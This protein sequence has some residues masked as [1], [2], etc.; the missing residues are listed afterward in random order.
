MMRYVLTALF[1]LVSVMVGQKSDI[2]GVVSDSAS[3]E[4][5]PYATVRIVELSRGSVTNNNGFYLIAGIPP[6]VYT[7]SAH[8]IGYPNQS[9]QVTI[10]GGG[11]V[12]VNFGLSSAPVELMGVEVIGGRKSE[13]SEISTSTHV[14]SQTDISHVPVIGQGDLFRSI[15][16]LP[17][18]VS[19]A[20]V[21]SKFFVRGGGGDQN[22]IL[23]DGLKI[24]NPFHA[25]G[26]FSI[27]DPEIVKSTEVYTGGFPAG[28][29][30]RLSSVVNII[31][32][33]GNNT[34]FKGKAGLN[35][36]SGSLQLE[37]PLPNNNSWIVSMRR[38]LFDD[39][40]NKFLR[41]PPPISFYDLF[42]KAKFG[43]GIYGNYSANIFIS[44]DDIVSP[45]PDEPDHFWNTTAASL[46]ISDLLQDRVYYETIISVN[47]FSISR[48]AKNSLLIQPAQSSIRDISIRTDLTMY[49][50]SE[51]LYFLGFEV[52]GIRYFFEYTTASKK[53][54][55]VDKSN[56]EFWSWFRYRTRIGKIGLDIGLHSDLI[57]LVSA[58]ELTTAFQ[59]RMNISYTFDNEWRL[60]GSYGI[61]TQRLMTLTNE[62]DIVS[63]FEA[64]I[65]VPKEDQ[66]QKASHYTIGLEGNIF[67]ELSASVQY[68]LKNYSSLALY[69]RD[70]KFASDP[71]YMRGTGRAYGIETMV[72][73]SFSAVDLYLAYTWGKTEVSIG[74]YTYPP[75]YDRR[76][77]LHL[78]G[79][80]RVWDNIECSV[81]WELGSGYAYS[82]TIG[83]YQRL[84]LSGLGRDSFVD[85]TGSGYLIIGDKNA[86]R[87]PAYHR[88]DITMT[89]RFHF[90][91]LAGETGVSIINAYD[92]RNILY[93]D[94]KTSQTITMLPFFPA[95]FVRV[96]F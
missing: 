40:Y 79:I 1:C 11:P 92:N 28:F 50:E 3:G 61:F 34:T 66:P 87:M 60:K 20:D 10:R 90:S 54:I 52:S 78:L 57:G 81:K 86:A 6:G 58:S 91:L 19:T 8:S 84:T 88:M 39:S 5:I 24:Y 15:Q 36:L 82:Q 14:L 30:G 44:Q 62:D 85:E 71:D 64:W 38:S 2:R 95:A 68:Y 73:Y 41:N 72:R 16:I 83:L 27:I 23:L 33:D 29:G 25:F 13:I 59:P 21:S 89:Y 48:N 37:G 67:S 65:M 56:G 93:Y 22:L 32:E 42:A 9:R 26:L 35:F 12:T 4:K 49:T 96:E 53:R 76:H 74:S 31:T 47:N 69:N 75:R 7:V 17:G 55:A 51:D 46:K 18:V 80:V 94:R 70:K 43:G 77:N 63:L 45:S